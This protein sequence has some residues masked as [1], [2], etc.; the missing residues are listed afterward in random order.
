MLAHTLALNLERPEYAKAYNAV[1]YDVKERVKKLWFK[2]RL[3][4]RCGWVKVGK[5]DKHHGPQTRIQR[6]VRWFKAYVSKFKGAGAKA[7]PRSD[8]TTAGWSFLGTFLGLF[9]L[10]A[11]HYLVLVPDAD[12]PYAMMSPM[13]AS[14]ACLIY[15]APASPFGQ[16]KM[17]IFGHSLALIVAIS[18]DYLSNVDKYPVTGQVL[19]QWLATILVPAFA[20]AIMQATGTVNPP[21]AAAATIYI[22]GGKAIKAWGWMAI[23]MPNVLGCGSIHIYTRIILCMKVCI[24]TCRC[25]VCVYIGMYV[26]PYIYL[27]IYV[28]T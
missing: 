17:V 11:C 23:V 19:P 13:L 26:Y 28:G 3:V 18:M 10:S 12:F 16:P 20:I 6:A 15:G 1:T 9:V 14:L 8:F 21:S 24:Y 2:L 7:P 4:V 5:E 27:H 22:T 25:R